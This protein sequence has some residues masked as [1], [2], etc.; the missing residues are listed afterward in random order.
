M[1]HGKSKLEVLCDVLNAYKNHL[2]VKQIE[3]KF[4]GESFF[5]NEQFFFKPV[6]PPE[7]ENLIKCLDTN[8]AAGIDTIPPK[9]IKIAADF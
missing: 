3:N 8:K 2:S 1:S 6:T 4:N 5:G 9:L 7:I